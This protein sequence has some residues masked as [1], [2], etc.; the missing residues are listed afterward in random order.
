MT[1]PPFLALALTD[2]ARLKDPS[3]AASF[4]AL[5][6]EERRLRLDGS[7]WPIEGRRKDIYRAVS[8]WSPQGQ[9]MISE[10]R[11]RCWPARRWRRRSSP[12][13]LP[14]AGPAQ[15]AHAVDQGLALLRFAWLSDAR[16]RWMPRAGGRDSG[17]NRQAA[18][19]DQ[20][21][22]TGPCPCDFRPRG[23]HMVAKPG[24]ERLIDRGYTT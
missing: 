3:I 21:S 18:Q 7:D 10:G 5:G 17:P 19:R 16:G 24:G 4:W 8:R 11:S 22:Q 6:P 1:R 15:A 14:K 12:E 2:W 13:L 20:Q 23:C 9:F